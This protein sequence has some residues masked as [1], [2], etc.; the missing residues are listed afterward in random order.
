MGCQMLSI[1]Q[2]GSPG[3][4]ACELLLVLLGRKNQNSFTDREFNLNLI[5]N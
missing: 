3:A 2:G 4:R 5:D 1:C